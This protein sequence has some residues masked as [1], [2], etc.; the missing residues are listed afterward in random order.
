MKLAVVDVR[1]S[2]VVPGCTLTAIKEAT[3]LHVRVVVIV[4]KT[5]IK[6]LQSVGPR[7]GC[8]TVG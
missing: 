4:V 8:K 7:R 5:L 3:A 6:T 2:L 1:D